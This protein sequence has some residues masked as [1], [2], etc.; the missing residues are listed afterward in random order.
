[1]IDSQALQAGVAGHLNVAR[2]KTPIVDIVRH[3][4]VDLGGDHQPVS[5]GAVLC[6]PFA[7]QALGCPDAQAPA[8]L[9]GGVDEVHARGEGGVENGEG[10]SLG[11]TR[12]EIHRAKADFADLEGGK[13]QLSILHRRPPAAGFMA[14]VAWAR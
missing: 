8:I 4:L 1:M 9:I 2:R 3:R 10:F 13:A 6:K 11:R 12:P 14:R 5:A 7:E